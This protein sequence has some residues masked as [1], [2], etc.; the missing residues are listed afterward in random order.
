MAIHSN[1]RRLHDGCAAR[2]ARPP[3]YG[4]HVRD[5]TGATCC[6]TTQRHSEP[7]TLP[8]NGVDL[9]GAGGGARAVLWVAWSQAG[10]AAGERSADTA[11]PA[12]AGLP[13]QRVRITFSTVWLAQAQARV[14]V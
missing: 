5:G 6:E 9:L 14:W 3:R 8:R 7:Y 10:P 4:E 11:R 13:R 2:L 1:T 12:R